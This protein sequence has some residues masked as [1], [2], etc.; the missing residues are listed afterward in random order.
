M[1]VLFE[2]NPEILGQISAL[3]QEKGIQVCQTGTVSSLIGQIGFSGADHDAKIVLIGMSPPFSGCIDLIN[4]IQ[5][6]KE[7]IQLFL[8]Y[9]APP[10]Y[11]QGL[12]AP[13][14]LG[15]LRGFPI[16]KADIPAIACRMEQFIRSI[17]E[18]D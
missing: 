8:Y 13:F 3:L 18:G 9:P 15:A 1:P 2:T 12:P 14:G 11:S 17:Y 16:L 5:R 10:G 6:F 7:G 4:F